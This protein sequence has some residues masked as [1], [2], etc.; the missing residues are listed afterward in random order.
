MPMPTSCPNAHCSLLIAHVQPTKAGGS[1]DPLESHRPPQVAEGI[2]HSPLTALTPSRR[3][4]RQVRPVPSFP[5]LPLPPPAIRIAAVSRDNRGAWHLSTQV[6]PGGTR[7]SHSNHHHD[8]QSGADTNANPQL[9]PTR[10]TPRPSRSMRP[11]QE[12]CSAWKTRGQ[13]DCA[14]VPPVHL[15]SLPVRQQ[16]TISLACMGCRL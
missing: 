13:T 3:G 9:E 2:T 8:P 7:S 12:V 4:D 10:L 5:P 14:F 1:D 11:C 15:R 16:G 6:K